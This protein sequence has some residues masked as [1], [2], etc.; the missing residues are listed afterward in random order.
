[1]DDAAS[2]TPVSLERWKQLT[3]EIYGGCHYGVVFHDTVNDHVRPL[4]PPDRGYWFA[5]PNQA[6]AYAHHV[7]AK[8]GLTGR[9]Y[10]ITDADDTCCLPSAYYQAGPDVRHDS[11]SFIVFDPEECET[12]ESIKAVISRAVTNDQDEMLAVESFE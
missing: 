4:H 2:P 5:D 1:M 6:T 10:L 9:V 12:D 11:D 8:I 3:A 7:A